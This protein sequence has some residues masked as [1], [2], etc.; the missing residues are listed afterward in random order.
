MGQADESLAMVSLPPDHCPRCGTELVAADAPGA[1]RCGSCEEHAF[2]DPDPN[3]RVAVLDGDRLLLVAMTETS[4]LDDPPYDEEWCPP[5]GHLN[6]GE[7]PGAAAARELREETGLSVDPGELVL[8]DAV[9][10]QA[11][12]GAHGLILVYAVRREATTGPLR[13]A[14]DAA[15]ARFWAPG[16]LA[17]TEAAFREMYEEPAACADVDWWRRTARRAL[18]TD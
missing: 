8:A 2:H 9:A 5:G 7:Q 11:I 3:A 12:A 13:A 16:E 17:A 4:R 10:R 18:R 15:A 14:D 6:P 1:Y